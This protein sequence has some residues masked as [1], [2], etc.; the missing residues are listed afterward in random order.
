[1]T[2]SLHIRNISQ[3][4]SKA[5]LIEFIE[6]K[7]YQYGFKETDQIVKITLKDIPDIIMMEVKFLDREQEVKL[8]VHGAT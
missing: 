2:P 7:L 1:M 4:I 3:P 5:K 8:T 6:E